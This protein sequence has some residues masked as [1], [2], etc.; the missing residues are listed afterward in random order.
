MPSM[1]KV[2]SQDEGPVIA[3][4]ANCPV[5]APIVV[6]HQH[7]WKVDSHIRQLHLHSGHS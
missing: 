6:G 3:G 1:L 7:H 4:A 5:L 2:L